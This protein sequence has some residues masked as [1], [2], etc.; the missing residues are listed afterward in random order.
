MPLTFLS[1]F[2]IILCSI[3]FFSNR[4]AKKDKQKQTS[5]WQKEDE[6]NRTRKQD[7]SNLRYITL[8]ENLVSLSCDNDEIAQCK[9]QV[10][11]LKDAP[12]VNLTGLTN[13]E[14]KLTYGAAN[15]EALSEY[16]ENFTSLCRSLSEWGK[17]YLSIGNLTDAC[18]V[19]EYAVG[20]GSDISETYLML[21]QVYHEN[22]ADYKIDYLLTKASQLTSLSKDVII[23]KLNAFVHH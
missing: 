12:I 3:R 8:P 23:S 1:F 17:S 2:I 15:L 20:I 4:T 7:L 13:T 16:D 14:L 11:L 10:L 6:S 22:H 18:T 21:A 5:F 19:L 9:D